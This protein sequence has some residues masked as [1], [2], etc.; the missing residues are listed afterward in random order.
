MTPCLVLNKIIPLVSLNNSAYTQS[1]K[2][3]EYDVAED[4]R[5]T[6]KQ[7][8]MNFGKDLKLDKYCY[9]PFNTITVDG[10]GDVYVCICQAWLP[11]SV[12]K[13]WDFDSLQAIVQSPRAREIQ[14]SILDRSYR[15]CDH[16]TCSI[17]QEGEL[18]NRIEHRPDTVN[19][20][21][22]SIDSSCNLTCPSCRKDFIFINE[23]NAKAWLDSFTKS[24]GPSSDEIIQIEK[25]I[26]R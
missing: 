13:I 14:S 24:L 10:F 26:Q 22:F 15:Y 17:I 6:Y 3:T 16:N 9:H 21:N 11:I 2:L 5:W 23:R 12:G 7:R 25:F 19:W 4:H 20:I 18:E 1:G 8:G